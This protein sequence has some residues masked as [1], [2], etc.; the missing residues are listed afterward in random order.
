[1][2]IWRFVGYDM[3]IFLGI[4]SLSSE[5][6]AARIDG[7]NDCAAAPAHTSRSRSCLRPPSSR[8]PSFITMFQNFETV[9]VMTAG[10]R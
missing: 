9:Y 5:L 8:S 2:T 4:Q 3:L 10:G 1:M 7:A 6:E